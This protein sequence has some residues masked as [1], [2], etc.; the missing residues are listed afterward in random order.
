MSNWPT[1]YLSHRIIID[2]SDKF[3]P[4]SCRR[5]VA[6][7]GHLPT[8]QLPLYVQCPLLHYIIVLNGH[9]KHLEKRINHDNQ[10]LF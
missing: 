1:V 9:I 8:G 4:E 2:L 6:M 7:L 10:Y 5:I 3:L